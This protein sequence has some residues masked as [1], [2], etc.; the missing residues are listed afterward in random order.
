MAGKTR[1]EWRTEAEATARLLSSVIQTGA[2]PRAP[3]LELFSKDGGAPRRR[4]PWPARVLVADHQLHS[5]VVNPGAW[6]I[7]DGALLIT[8]ANGTA[9]YDV[10]EYYPPDG[11]RVTGYA[12]CDRIKAVYDG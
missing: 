10:T 4:A 8:C 5:A 6:S 11:E 12:V 3:R 9:V 2:P 7:E 1:A